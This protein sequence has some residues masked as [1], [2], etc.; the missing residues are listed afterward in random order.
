[1]IEALKEHYDEVKNDPV[2]FSIMPILSILPIT[3]SKYSGRKT[4]QLM[5]S[6]DNRISEN[7]FYVVCK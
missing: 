1:M 6:S 2:F 7:A 3:Y 5:S 4:P